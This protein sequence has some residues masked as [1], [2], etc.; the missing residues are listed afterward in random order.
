MAR[1]R[2]LVDKGSQG[3]NSHVVTFSKVG[4]KGWSLPQAAELLRQGYTDRHVEEVT[5]F[6]ARVVRNYQGGPS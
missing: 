2:R 4:G 1:R 5:G 6:D 3:H